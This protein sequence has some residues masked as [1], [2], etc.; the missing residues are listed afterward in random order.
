MLIPLFSVADVRA[1]LP[2]IA[3][4]PGESIQEA[5]NKVKPGGL[6][7]ISSGV[8]HELITINKSITITGAG[9]ESTIIDG[10]ATSNT[11]LIICAPRVKITMLTIQ[12]TSRSTLAGFPTGI[13]IH[14]SYNV[15]LEQLVIKETSIGIQ[16]T[17]S[18]FN[19][20]SKNDIYGNYYAGILINSKS[21]QN[22]ITLN[23]IKNNNIGL[24]IADSSCQLNRIYHNNFIN[25]T[26]QAQQFG[27]QNIWDNGY[28]SG[29][30]YWSDHKA[31]D[32][33]SG[34][35]QTEMGK[36][37]IIDVPYPDAYSCWDRYPL[38]APVKCSTIEWQGNKFEIIT[39]SNATNIQLS[40]NQQT[41]S[42]YLNFSLNKPAGMCRATIPKKLL[43][44]EKL[45]EWSIAY[46]KNNQTIQYNAQEDNENTYLFFTFS[47]EIDN[48]IRI[49]AT[50]VIPE[51]QGVYLQ[52]LL[53]S[54][55]LSMTLARFLKRG[56]NIGKN[57]DNNIVKAAART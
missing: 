55:T 49:T 15:T 30:N 8:Y 18:S 6:V 25:N 51:F 45:S 56:K 20:I 40:F 3:V 34:Q 47:P 31:D 10:S 9:A 35:N 33:K 27:G 50:N 17:N 42:L 39:I 14:N 7:F 37:G 36:D 2:F 21:N 57:F 32:L 22:T 43:W 24:S 19:I 54:L 12:N 29:G 1:E 23:E 48:E 4:R 28:P 53:F 38:S 26:R 5:I 46:N 41:K 11:I 52:I 16:V 13:H 44:C